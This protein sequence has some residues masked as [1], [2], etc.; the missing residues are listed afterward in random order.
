MLPT[1]YVVVLIT[2]EHTSSSPGYIYD[3]PSTSGPV[4]DVRIQRVLHP[5][6]PD[7]DVREIPVLHST[8]LCSGACVTPLPTKSRTN[9]DPLNPRDEQYASRSSRAVA[10]GGAD[11]VTDVGMLFE[12]MDL[13]PEVQ[14]R[15][16]P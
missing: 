1:G 2:P 16:G 12:Q 4:G 14:L 15:P 11:T 7:S 3:L 9:A 13:M 10:L 5:T 6:G 8:F